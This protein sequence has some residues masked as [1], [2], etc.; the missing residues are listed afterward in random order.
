[1][2]VRFAVAFA[3]ISVVCNIAAAGTVTVYSF[4][5]L[6]QCKDGGVPQA[7]PT[8]ATI[9]T[10]YGTTSAGGASGLGTVFKM[11]ASGVVTSLIS[12]DGTNGA[13]PVASLL[14]ANDGNLYG[15]AAGGGAAGGECGCGIAFKMSRKG[16]EKIVH[17]FAQSD[18]HD[19]F[20]GLVKDAA[21][22]FYGTAAAGGDAD[23]FGAVY[24][25]T[26]RQR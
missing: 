1:M 19:P 16:A 25:I 12:F 24:E 14:A 6:A 8:I 22:N 5:S 18:G 3:A 15:T 9:G 4:C 17:T 11:T 23:G 26:T 13:T 7:P 10:L 20:A 21:G 2:R